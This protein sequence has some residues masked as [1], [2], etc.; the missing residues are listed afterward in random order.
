MAA[1]GNL[2]LFL[3]RSRIGH[4]RTGFVDLS[5]G[6]SVQI[7]PALQGLVESQVRRTQLGVQPLSRSLLNRLSSLQPNALRSGQLGSEHTQQSRTTS[8]G[9]GQGIFVTYGDNIV[10]QQWHIAGVFHV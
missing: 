9:A 8:A 4:D 1:F 7:T 5:A 3:R 6:R 2:A 10:I